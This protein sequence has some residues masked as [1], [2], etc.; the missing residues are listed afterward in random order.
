MV[1][2]LERSEWESSMMDSNDGGQEALASIAGLR[3]RGAC[4]GRS[5]RVAQLEPTAEIHWSKPCGKPASKCGWNAMARVLTY[6]D[7][8]PASAQ[9]V[10][11]RLRNSPPWKNITIRACFA[12]KGTIF[13]GKLVSERS[14]LL[15]DSI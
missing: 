5:A 10:S 8:R 13:E 12:A 3:V 11:G 4:A 14:L 6:H 9:T 7:Q 1:K 2:I 15:L